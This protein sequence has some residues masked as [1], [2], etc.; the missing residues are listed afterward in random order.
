L[1]KAIRSHQITTPNV[2]TTLATGRPNACNLCHLDRSL[3]WTAD[4][5][6]ARYGITAPA[7]SA[8]DQA[9]P[10]AFSLALRGDAAQR[11]LIAWSF[12]WQSAQQASGAAWLPLALAPLLDDPYAAVRLIAG[13][14]LRS[15]PQFAD[16]EYDAIAAPEA[17]VDAGGRVRARVL[18][19]GNGR[20]LRAP[21]A[22]LDANGQ[23]DTGL[24]SRLLADR[25]QR[26][27]QL[28]E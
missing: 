2:A 28:L 24:V 7:L 27:I 16:F 20:Q 14:S 25:D 11:A 12:G 9:L 18:S 19:G 21:A 22:L 10:A 15:F 3:G 8:D 17:R 4:Q 26:P 6:S 23:L 1:L 5:L 13:R